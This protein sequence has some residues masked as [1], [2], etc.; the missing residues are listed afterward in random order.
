MHTHTTSRCSTSVSRRG[1]V[2]C[3]TPQR[4][5]F[6]RV[7]RLSLAACQRLPPVPPFH[8]P[9]IPSRSLFACT[10]SISL[11]SLAVGAAA[12]I[13]AAFV[14]FGLID[15][16]VPN[17]FFLPCLLIAAAVTHAQTGAADLHAGQLPVEGHQ[18]EPV[19][20]RRRGRWRRG[21]WRRGRGRGR[22]RAGRGRRW[23]G[24]R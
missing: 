24:R 21:R 14:V 4:G 5:L 17:S 1:K 6:R 11:L 18:P 12:V 19:W 16:F 9:S 22:R 2:C 10:Q 13:S 8:L 3:V 20:R 15:A 23:R 7:L